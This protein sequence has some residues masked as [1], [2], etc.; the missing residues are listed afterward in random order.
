L[1]R[2]V[3]VCAALVGATLL[4]VASA[5]TPKTAPCWCCHDGKVFKSAPD[6]CVEIG[7]TCY[8]SK[9]QANVGCHRAP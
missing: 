8:A 9:K 5:A 4:T 3:A 7:G 1:I 6:H 2:N